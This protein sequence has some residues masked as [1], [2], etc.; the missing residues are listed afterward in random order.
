MQL[1]GGQAMA[2]LDRAVQHLDHRGHRDDRDRQYLVDDLEATLVQ[3]PGKDRRCVQRDAVACWA[4]RPSRAS[5]AAP[6][7]ALSVSEPL[8]ASRRANPWSETSLSSARM[9]R[10]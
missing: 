1:S 3:N 6:A 8:T 5:S 9:A 10:T 7:A 2:S 4:H